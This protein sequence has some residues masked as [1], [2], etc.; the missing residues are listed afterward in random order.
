MQI[1]IFCPIFPGSLRVFKCFFSI[2]SHLT[3]LLIFTS[4]ISIPSV[5]VTLLSPFFSDERSEIVKIK[6]TS[7]LCLLPASQNFLVF[8]CL[9]VC[10]F[11]LFWPHLQLVEIPQP[12]IKSKPHLRPTVQQH[13]ILNP[14]HWAGDQIS[15]ATETS[16]IINPLYHSGNY[17]K[18]ILVNEIAI[19]LP[20]E[21]I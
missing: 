18:V 3:L 7:F 12:G 8:V 2:F 20:K 19:C 6:Y 1:I 21:Q 17:Q 13:Q 5:L 15:N 4:R 11:F 16:L 10:L 9:F 14:L